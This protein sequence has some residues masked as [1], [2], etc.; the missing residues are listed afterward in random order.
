M[1]RCMEGDAP[2]NLSNLKLNAIEKKNNWYA[3][4]TSSV[5]AR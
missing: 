4:V 2:V 5:M 1:D 3:M